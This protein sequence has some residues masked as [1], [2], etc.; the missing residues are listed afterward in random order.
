MTLIKDRYLNVTTN[1]KWFT[2]T[3]NSGENTKLQVILAYG[4]YGRAAYIDNV[5]VSKK[6]IVC[7]NIGNNGKYNGDI[8]KYAATGESITFF[9]VPNTGYCGRFSSGEY[10]ADWQRFFYRWFN[11]DECVSKNATY[12]FSTFSD[13]ALQVKFD[14]NG[15]FVDGI[16]DCMVNTSVDNTVAPKTEYFDET[17]SEF[18]AFTDVSH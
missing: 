13:I 12:A 3:F 10:N 9:V 6:C 1:N 5:H 4:G 15:Q 16:K 11:E 17:G 14:S 8:P 18:S 7:V 2:N